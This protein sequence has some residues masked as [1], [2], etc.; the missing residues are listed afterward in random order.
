MDPFP[1]GSWQALP[2]ASDGVYV[3]PTSI[4]VIQTEENSACRN[5]YDPLCVVHL[6]ILKVDP[7][8]G[9][10][11]TIFSA[12][13]TK[14]LVWFSIEQIV[15]GSDGTLFFLAE[16]DTDN[17]PQQ[18]GGTLYRVNNDGRAVRLVSPS[19]LALAWAAHEGSVR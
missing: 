14:P 7:T 6:D 15:F 16:T 10:S 5:Q 2:G 19:D 4:G 11:T 17:Q 12:P 1:Q 8:S 3:S 9:K 13:F 18:S